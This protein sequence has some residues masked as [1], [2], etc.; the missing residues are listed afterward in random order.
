MYA[1]EHR[2]A[3]PVGKYTGPYDLDGVK[4]PTPAGVYPFWPNFLAKYATK[5]KVGGGAIS[6]P[7]QQTALRTIFWGCPAWE[8]YQ[9]G[10]MMAQTGYGMNIYPTF[11][12]T[13]PAGDFPPSQE[14][15]V[16]PG[17]SFMRRGKWASRSSERALVTDGRF[18]QAFSHQLPS[19]VFPPQSTI[20]NSF[21]DTPGISPPTQT[22]VDVYRHGKYPRPHQTIPDAFSQLGGIV[23]YNILYCDGH[24]DK[25]STQEA[26]YRS[27]RMRFPG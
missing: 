24:V 6:A 23:A 10:T 13:H 27:I 14:I 2:D 20:N 5:S 11:S 15:A 17:G 12:A 16:I 25:A 19:T 8:P 22:W 3:F 1:G 4:Y 26:A 7:E 9:T 21:T 18:W